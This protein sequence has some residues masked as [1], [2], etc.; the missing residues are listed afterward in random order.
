[1]TESLE[2][3]STNEFGL[4]KFYTSLAQMVCESQIFLHY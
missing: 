3:F 4:V 2:S 1:M